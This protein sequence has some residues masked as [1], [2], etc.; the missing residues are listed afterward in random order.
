M[1][2]RTLTLPLAATA[3]LAALV[4]LDAGTAAGLCGRL[5]PVLAFAAGMSVTV[6]LAA[7]ARLFE[8]AVAALDRSVGR[9]EIVLAG[10]LSLCVVATMFLSLDTTAVMLTPLAA[11]LCRRFGFNPVALPLAVI[12]IANLASLPLPVS[13]LT[14]LLA[15][16][17][18]AFTSARDYRATA[19]APAAAG[20]AVALAAS[21]LVRLRHRSTPTATLTATEEVP[22]RPTAALA[23]VAAT[24]LFL[25]T[26][27]PYWATSTIAAVA[28]WLT[29]E[30]SARPG[31]ASLIPWN[32]LLLT[33]AVSAAA[34]LVL[35]LGGEV[36]VKQALGDATGPATAASGALAANLLNNIPAYFALEPATEG[37]VET[38]A[39]LIGVNFGP[40]VTP[41]AS[42]AT[43]LWAD[44]LKRAGINAPWKQFV[45]YGLLVAPAAIV[46]ALA[47]LG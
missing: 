14:N 46:A 2:L 30:K 45:G 5:L 40:V 39:L 42:L 20:I 16:G 38:L 27:V 10:F 9:R 33:T 13:N 23:V 35:T 36:V 1:N 8:W 29:T 12:W 21:Y 15:F 32:A 11:V 43:L 24:L 31:P 18:D 7:R 34:T 44:Q 3:G 22:T 17:A 6:N 26:P 28:I 25:L 37:A 41:W 19:A 47:T 4:A